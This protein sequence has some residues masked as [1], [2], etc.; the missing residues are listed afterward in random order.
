MSRRVVR[1]VCP[2][3]CYCTC[4]MLA[5]VEDGRL[6]K[7][8]GDPENPATAGEVCVKGLS[9]VERVAHETR[10]TSPLRRNGKGQLEPVSWD[11]ALDEI[12]AGLWSIRKESGPLA[13]L[14]YEGSGSHGALS[15]LS[16]AFW[17]PFGG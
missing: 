5:T 14:H 10:L 13:V 2:R 7:I 4:G 17:N 12:V 15:G 16:E 9:Y 6:V 1:T 11:D 8:E 3:N